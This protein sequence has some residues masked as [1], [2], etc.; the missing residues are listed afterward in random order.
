MF[1]HME[2]SPLF[3]RSCNVKRRL[4]IRVSSIQI[5]TSLDENFS[6][7]CMTIPSRTV[8]WGPAI[9]VCSIRVCTSIDKSLSHVQMSLTHCD[10]QGEGGVI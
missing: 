1:N 8:Q 4:A 2:N 10:V 5:S 3:P 9:L 6:D 7:F